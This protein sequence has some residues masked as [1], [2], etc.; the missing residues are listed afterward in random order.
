MCVQLGRCNPLI[1]PATHCV[2]HVSLRHSELVADGEIDV[3]ND[4][5]PF[6]PGQVVRSEPSPT[7][8]RITSPPM[9][10]TM[11]DQ[12]PPPDEKLLKKQLEI[13]WR[14]QYEN[15]PVYI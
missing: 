11:Y 4:C 2:C 5:Q 13:R 7:P 8:I 1:C 15:K 12:G 6:H 3:V 14:Y 10:F 9:D